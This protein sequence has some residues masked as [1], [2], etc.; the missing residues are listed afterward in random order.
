MKTLKEQF[1]DICFQYLKAFNEKHELELE[2][3]ELKTCW[4]GDEVGGIADLNEMFIN[5]D[6]IRYDI[7][8]DVETDK[9]LE[10]YWNNVERGEFGI[11]Y[12]NYPAFC[13]G[14]PD[15]ITPE[16]MEEIKKCRKRLEEAQQAFNDSINDYKEPSKLF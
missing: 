6:V 13:K 10:W 8:N 14:A 1:E 11:K 7:D 16:K 2:D 15:H 9:F 5:F 12:M 4:I 3:Y